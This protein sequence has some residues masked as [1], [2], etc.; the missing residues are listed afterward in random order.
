MEYNYEESLR[1]M[2]EY[3]AR[4]ERGATMNLRVLPVL[5]QSTVAAVTRR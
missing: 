5:P 1:R 3:V 2:D 4:L